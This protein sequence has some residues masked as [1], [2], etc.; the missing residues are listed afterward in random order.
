[1]DQTSARALPLLK[2]LLCSLCKNKRI[3][4]NWQ[5][6]GAKVISR[7][8]APKVEPFKSIPSATTNYQCPP[9][10]LGKKKPFG[11]SPPKELKKTVPCKMLEKN[12]SSKISSTHRLEIAAPKPIILPLWFHPTILAATELC[13][14]A[15]PRTQPQVLIAA[16]E[17][18]EAPQLGCIVCDH[19]WN[20]GDARLRATPEIKGMPGCEKYT[21]H[22]MSLVLIYWVH[23]SE[24]NIWH[25]KMY[26]LDDKLAQ[27]TWTNKEDLITG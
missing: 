10:C 8:E 23:R 14:Y 2:K 13:H 25:E 1:M 27:M 6:M 16:D 17:W 22:L 7:T 18:R 15:N 3:Q 11:P 26:A 20:L 4:N 21:S 5:L 19:L 9:A 24:T 12:H